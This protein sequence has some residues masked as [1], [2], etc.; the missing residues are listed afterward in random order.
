MR[1]SLVVVLGMIAW[2]LLGAWDAAGAGGARTAQVV[3]ETPAEAAAS[4]LAAAVALFEGTADPACRPGGPAPVCVQASSTPEEAAAGIATFGV[5]GSGPDGEGSFLGILGRDPAGVWH[6]WFGTQNTTYQALKLP[7]ELTVCA[8]GATLNVRAGPSTDHAIVSTLADL[9]SVTAEQFTLTEAGVMPAEST[10]QVVGAG[11]Y[12]LSTPV[13]GWAYSRY[14]ADAA[15]A[16]VVGEGPC[17]LRDLF[18]RAR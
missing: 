9:T 10:D 3:S 15:P 2:S 4:S 12:Q 11:W 5:S 1:R 8:E 14:L 17:F 6:F 7:A 18:E 16:A 13:E